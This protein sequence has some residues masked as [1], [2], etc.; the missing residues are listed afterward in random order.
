MKYKKILFVTTRYP[1]PVTGGDKLRIS[2]IMR[3]LS[4]KNKI[5]LISIGNE[6]KKINFIEKQY[7][8]KNNIINK[9]FYILK[10]FFKNEPLQVGLYKLPLMKKKI[11]E[12]CGDYDVIIFHL[13][14]STYYFS[15]TFKGIKI[16]E[17]TDLIS[18]NYE[19]VE[20]NLS[21]INPL[22]YIYKY[23]KIKL[24]SYEINQSKKFDKIV[25]VNKQDIYNSN[26]KDN[27][28]IIVIG[29]GT[30]LKENVF[31]KNKNKKN[32]IFFGNINSL[33]NRD[34]CIDFIDN[35]LPTLKKNY[36]NLE[37]KIFGNCSKILKI[38]FN[39]K[40]IEV[41][42]NIN[43]LKFY[44]KNTLAGICNVKIQSGL[45]NKILDYTSIGLP[46][47]IN[48]ISNNFKLLKGKNIL[49]Y[50]DKSEFFFNLNKLFKNNNLRNK[51]S[52]MNFNKTKKHFMWK[53]IL[54]NYSNI[55]K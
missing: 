53:K 21:F 28:K 41:K 27:K 31:F 47:I 38:F 22:K 35:Y 14:R 19:T 3:F 37:F 23:E 17:M 33:A 46:V 44:C 18:K 12:I 48:T 11:G 26:I 39:L 32:I 8:F 4:K 51:I 45:Q 36:P 49:V 9:I 16:L 54:I 13:I 29:N 6:R 15:D 5:D 30:H 1:F 42:S 10:S 7:I 20:K 2:E 24:K 50:K 52:N 25:F 43:N 40:G 55:I 34:A